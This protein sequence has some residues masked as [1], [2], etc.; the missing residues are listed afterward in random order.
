[1]HPDASVKKEDSNKEISPKLPDRVDKT[2]KLL[3]ERD[4]ELSK[5]KSELA[6][7]IKKLEEDE[8]KLREMNDILEIRLRARTRQLREIISI[9]NK[10]AKEKTKKLEDSNKAL[11]NI[12]EDFKILRDRAEEEKEK[13]L[14]IVSSFP[15]GLLVFDNKNKLLVMNKRAEEF[16]GLK[17]KKVIGKSIEELSN[18]A[19]F[20]LLINAIGKSINE[21]FRKELKINENLILEVSV[22]S[23]RGKKK[24]IGKFVVLHDITR[25]KAIEKLKSDFVSIAAHQLRTPLSAI[26]WTLTT[27]LEGDFGELN[28][29]QREYLEK[30]NLS[31]ERMINLVDDLLNLSRIEEGKYVRKDEFF[32]LDKVVEKTIE[33]LKTEIKK[34]NL[35]VSFKKLRKIPK[36]LA[37]KEKI[38]LA[39]QNLIENAVNYTLDNG[40]IK[41]SLDFNGE[42]IKFSVSDSGIGIPQDQ[43][44]KIFSRFFRSAKAKKIRTE[45]SGLGL[46]ITKNIIESHGGKIWFESKENE[47]TTFYFTIPAKTEF[48]EFLR[49]F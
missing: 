18:I 28:P 36:I 13:T 20:S 11:L 47:G 41:I 33:S 38:G 35:K 4:L 19:A 5:V 8:E 26:K 44:K 37:D 17:G 49:K 34:K 42:E 2:A 12:L 46:Y 23:M 32:E 22:V 7:K 3:L 15:D 16:L 25:E 30:A 21:V 24:E 45:G 1:M 48:K 31:N 43:Q 6:R 14:A 27:L 39:V 9:L 40:Q 29:E 10:Q